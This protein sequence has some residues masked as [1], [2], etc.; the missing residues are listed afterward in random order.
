MNVILMVL[1]DAMKLDN[2]NVKKILKVN[3][4]IIAKMNSLDF[5]HVKLV[6]VIR[7]VLMA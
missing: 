7:M 4:V 2:V 6:I 5:L 3:N 1:M